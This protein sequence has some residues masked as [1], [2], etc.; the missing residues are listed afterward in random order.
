MNKESLLSMGRKLNDVVYV[1][2]VY[3]LEP[4]GIII[5]A[6]NQLDSKER[7]LPITEMEVCV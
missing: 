7:I 2:S 1:L 5:H 4:S 3:D 6:Y